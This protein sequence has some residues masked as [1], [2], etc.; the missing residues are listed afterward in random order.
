MAHPRSVA[1]SD[2]FARGQGCPGYFRQPAH[3]GLKPEFAGFVPR[4]RELIVLRLT[5]RQEMSE[6]NNLFD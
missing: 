4:G 1:S 5:T 6:V 3:I 2:V